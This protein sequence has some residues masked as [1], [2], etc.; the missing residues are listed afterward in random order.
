M[1]PEIDRVL[2]EYR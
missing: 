2:H 1:T